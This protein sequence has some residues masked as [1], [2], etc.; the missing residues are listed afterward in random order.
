[1]IFV[2]WWPSVRSPASL[3]EG[4]LTFLVY[5]DIN[6]QCIHTELQISSRKGISSS[7]SFY[8]S[9]ILS[10]RL[11]GIFMAMEEWFPIFP[12][13]FVSPTNL[14]LFLS[15]PGLITMSEGTLHTKART[16]LVSVWA[17]FERWYQTSPSK[18]WLLPYYYCFSSSHSNHSNC[19]F[20][21]LDIYQNL[22]FRKRVDVVCHNYVTV[23]W[24]IPGYLY[25]HM[26]QSWPY[27]EY[28][29]DGETL[30]IKCMRKV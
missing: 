30:K 10:F 15:P 22:T 13:F 5:L 26:E 3:V 1:M 29:P 2:Y 24:A 16:M 17:R 6:W 9:S 4:R 12:Q 20:P 23:Q 7:I 19:L 8:C 18:H 21:H 25:F 28:I 27:N 11:L 14:Q